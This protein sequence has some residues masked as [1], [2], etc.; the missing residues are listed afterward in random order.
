MFKTRV[1]TLLKSIEADA[2]YITS[3]ENMRYYSGFT[4]G[5][6]ALILRPDA[7]LLL[8]DSRYLL[9][10]AQ[11][12]PDFTVVDITKTKPA[13]CLSA[14]HPAAIGFEE[15]FVSAKGYQA[16]CAAMPECRFL[17][18]DRTMLMQ[19]AAKDDRELMLTRKAA[20]LADEAFSRVLPLIKPGVSEL[21]LALELEWVMRKGGASAPSFPII[22]ASGKRSAMPHGTA[23]P[24]KLAAGDFVTMDFGCFYE[25]YASDMTRTVVL[26][27]AST[28]Q[29]KIYE[30]VLAAQEA[31]LAMIGAGVVCKDADAAA[32]DVI[33]A[34]GYGS[35]FGHALGHG[36]GLLI[37]EQP[38]LS[39]RSETVLAAGMMVT[40]EPGIY[41]ENLGGVRIEDLVV[42]TDKGCE[43]LTHS[44]K[45]LLEL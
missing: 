12:A 27:R 39:P 40:V 37:H 20:A 24:K 17:G 18:V 41:V 4:G 30:T 10:A 43:N 28:E 19:R 35:C 5:E 36:T 15:E 13:D 29:K 9:Q 8:T 44:E 21:D 32:R 25:G 33:T 11:E 22:C 14:Y 2:V 1:Q 42:I 31:A 7:R 34:A 38:V 45:A 16:L 6:G 3:P 23:T 26:G